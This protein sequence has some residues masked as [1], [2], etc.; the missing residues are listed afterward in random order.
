MTT[1]TTEQAVPFPFTSA[2]PLQPAP[3]YAALRAGRPALRVELPYGGEGWLVSRYADVKQVLSDP[4]F[5]RAA[6]VNAD[7]PRTTPARPQPNNLL[8][9]DAPEHSRLR[10]LV[11]GT[12]TMKNIE[13]WRPRTEQ[14]VQQLI[15]GMRRGGSPADLVNAFSLPLPVT[16]ICELLGVPA[17]E[18]PLFQRFSQIILSTTAATLDEIITARTDLENYLAGHIAAHREQPRDDLLSQLISARD[19]GDRL[20]EP[21]LVSMGITILVAGH[22]T[23]ANQ[24]S[25]F[26]YTLLDAGLWADLAT[27]PERL[28]TAIEELL[29]TVALGTGGGQARIATEDIDIGGTLVRAGEAVIAALPSANRDETAF[30]SPDALDLGRQQNPHVAF[31][32]GLHHCLGAQLARLELRVGLGGLLAAFPAL[33]LQDVAWRVGTLVTGPSKLSVSW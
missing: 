19:E 16:V 3:E 7:V 2:E 13:R 24:L 12:F 23:T 14:I 11:A 4:R 18:R 31:G 6:T 21:E 9:M 17:S 27:H 26:V 15:D 22:E 25:N 10:R 8:S 20:S 28:T 30:Q 5:S 1:S 32:F 29:R 33:R